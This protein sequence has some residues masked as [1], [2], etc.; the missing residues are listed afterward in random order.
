M[1]ALSLATL[2]VQCGVN[3]ALSMAALGVFCGGVFVADP[4]LPYSGGGSSSG[5]SVPDA[6]THKYEFPIDDLLITIETQDQMDFED[7]TDMVSLIMISGA[8]E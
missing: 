8:L 3:K 2:G 4:V 1:S 6:Q 7:L 5:Y